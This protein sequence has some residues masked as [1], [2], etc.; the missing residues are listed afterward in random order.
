MAVIDKAELKAKKKVNYDPFSSGSL[1]RAVPTTEAQREI[2]ATLALDQEA[3]LCYNESLSVKISGELDLKILNLAYQEVLKRHDALRSF[4]SPDGKFFFVKE[5]KFSPLDFIDLSSRENSNAEFKALEDSQVKLQFDLLNGPCLST[6]VVKLSSGQF[7]ILLSAH[8]II[9]DGWS[10]TVLLTELSHLYSSLLNHR[11]ALLDMPTQFSDIALQEDLDGLNQDHK[12]YWL[13]QFSQPLNVEKLPLDFTRP[14]FR[15]YNSHRLDFVVP[16]E[17]VKSL[18]K[19]GASQGSSLYTVLMCGFQVFLSR[20]TNSHELVVGMA[21]A[22]QSSLGEN[23]LVGHMVSLLPLRTEVSQ[24]ATLKQFIKEIRSK[25]LDAFEHQQF[26]FGSLL[27]ELNLKRDPSEIP[28]VNV[29][30]N[31]DQQAPDQGLSFS[32][33]KARYSTIPRDFENFELFINAVSS[34]DSLTIECQY[35]VNLLKASTIE[36]WFSGYI[37]LLRSLPTKLELKLDELNI[38][39]LYFPESKKVVVEKKAHEKPRNKASEEKLLTIWKQVLNV[40]EIEVEENFFSLGGHSLLVIEMIPL[41]EKAFNDKVSARNIFENPTVLELSHYLNSGEEAAQSI[42]L[43]ISRN[44]DKTQF[45]VTHNQ[46]QVWYLEQL[47]PKTHMH[48]LPS[49]IRLKFAID[50]EAL[51]K[52]LHVLIRR[53][54]ALRTSIEVEEGVPVQKILSADLP[55]FQGKL[56]LVKANEKNIVELLNKEAEHVFEIDQ[57]PLFRAKLFELGAEDFVFYFMPHHAIWDGWSFDIFFEEINTAYTAIAQNRTPVFSHNPEVSYGDYS[58]WLQSAVEN[59]ELD[60]QLSYWKNR[61]K[62]PLPVLEMP[63][64]FKRPL[65]ASHEGQTF[66]FQLSAEQSQTLRTYAKKHGTSLFNVFL[67]AFKV[68]LARYANLEDIIVGSPVRSRNNPELLHTIGYFVNTV[69]LRSHIPLNKS[70]E[71]N[72]KTVSQTCVEAFDHQTLP[73]QVVLNNVDYSRDASRSPIFQTF[74]SYQ[75]TSNR[76]GV[77]NG[78]SYSQINID[79]ASLHTDLDLWIK[80]SDKK[81]EGAFEFRKDLFKTISIENFFN[82]FIYLMDNLLQKE[83]IP[84]AK[85][86]ILPPAQS[87]LILKDWNKTETTEQSFQPMYKGFERMVEKYPENLAVQNAKSSLS[88]KELNNEANRVAHALAAQGVIPGDLVGLC[89]NRDLNMLISILGIMKAGAG[90]VP[91]DPSFPQ[92]R[93]N[94]MVGSSK[95]KLLVTDSVLRKRFPDDRSILIEAILEDSS[96]SIQNPKLTS[97][98]DTTAYVIYTSGSTG[99]PKGVEVSHKALSNFLISMSKTP[100]IT[101]SDKLLAVTTLSFDIATLELYLPLITGASLYL[102]GSYDVID[103]KALRSI[104]DDHHISFMQATPST[105]RLLLSAGWNGHKNFKVLCGGEPFPKDLA[106]KLISICGSVWNMYGPTETTVWSTCHRLEN[107]LEFVS[108]GRPIDNTY[109]YILDEGLNLNPV[110]VSGQLYIGGLGLA[111]GYFKQ[112]DLTSEKF[113]PNPFVPGEKM[114]ATGDFARFNHEGELECLGRQDGQVKIR[115]YRIELGEIESAIS[116]IPS[117]KANAVITQ[118]V[119]PG[120]VRI[121]AFLVLSPN[122]QLQ[123]P[124]LRNSL[125]QVLPKYMIPSHF[126]VLKSL[127]QTLNGKIDKK[128]LIG[129]YTEVNTSSADTKDVSFVESSSG[130]EAEIRQMWQSILNIS[131]IRD[132]DNFFNI[133]GNSLLAVQLF[134]QISKRFKQN[135]PLSLLLGAS[136]FKSFVQ[137]IIPLVQSQAVITEGFLSLVPIKVEGSKNPVFAFH[138]V[139]GNVLNYVSLIPAFGP[140]RPLIGVQSLG[141]NQN[142]ENITLEEMA[143]AYIKEIQMH[144]PHG[145]YF[146]VGGS[147]GGVIAFEVAQQLMKKGESIERIVMFDTFGPRSNMKAFNIKEKSFFEK[148]KSFMSYR[149]Q[150]LFHRFKSNVLKMLGITLPIELLLFEVEQNNYKA[151][152]NYKPLSYSG[153]IHIIRAKLTTSGWYSDPSMGWG[154]IVKGQIKTYQISGSH[155]DFIESPELSKV[156]SGLL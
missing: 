60:H 75:D 123:E 59:G 23:D 93:L 72:L 114:Y 69:A 82:C 141:L 133:G 145:P 20:L 25:M 103:G 80:A 99:Q 124:I 5:Y 39:N 97:P 45:P 34:G 110:G 122:Y 68:T 135:L 64:D 131:A 74:F 107:N 71:E 21:S 138:G 129:L 43:K 137:S 90:Y 53:H 85:R 33:L 2:W 89:L 28:L 12:R 52:A 24:Q 88:Y 41:I 152:W 9:C 117:I 76:S 62:G 7:A 151:L 121:I 73:F 16:D 77:L 140:D 37:E 154:P 106:L 57:A 113:I 153:D 30:F 136:D 104:I 14:T 120:D 42:S 150:V 63:A 78:H 155:S 102:A 86:S 126:V 29:V 84:L 36:N 156:L 116:K 111:K 143:S 49:S 128:S 61:L 35:N 100:G 58:L 98:E 105:W 109:T 108:I 38:P 32:G 3:T 149:K 94:Y 70:F 146:L 67:T 31:I 65:V 50:R 11:P 6:T 17:V 40:S 27:K 22:G 46:L 81:I 112:P 96:L 54:S 83:N 95:P 139:G 47:F 4:F 13:K 91:L 44:E 130:P 134:S 101:P 48:N 125:L 132:A 66:G 144:Q 119:R 115:G 79:K 147:M 148:L 1:E 18:K 56:G 19:F 118:E 142:I 15:T 10:F 8:H 26:S 92:E 127:P 51:E 55:Q 87:K